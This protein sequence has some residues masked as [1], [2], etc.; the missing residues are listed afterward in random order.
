MRSVRVYREK[1]KFHVSEILKILKEGSGTF[2]HPG[3]VG[4][5]MDAFKD[6]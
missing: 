5:F 3:L 6:L 1:E 2:F 4:C